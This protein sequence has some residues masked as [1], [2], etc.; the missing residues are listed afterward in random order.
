MACGAE[1]FV[2][3]NFKHK[4]GIP[5]HAH[6]VTSDQALKQEGFQDM[7]MKIRNHHGKCKI[8]ILGGSHSA[9]SVLNILLNGP[10]RIKVFEDYK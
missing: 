9:F 1:Q 3:H 5:D 7:V 2:P 10:C 4:Y 8:F 6:V